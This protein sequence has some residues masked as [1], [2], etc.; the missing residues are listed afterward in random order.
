MVWVPYYEPF[1]EAGIP[2]IQDFN[3]LPR[4]RRQGIGMVLMDAAEA[5]I[6]TRST[7]AGS[8]WASIPT[9]ARPSVFMC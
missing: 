3:V 2:E 7:T 4:Y 8:G 6:A 5:L 1:R 9:M